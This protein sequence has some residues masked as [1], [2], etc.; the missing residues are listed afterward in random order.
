MNRVEHRRHDETKH[1]YDKQC[2]A[3]PGE[4]RIDLLR[5]VFKASRKLGRAKHEQ[6]IA[7]Y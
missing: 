7:K 6:K 4:I 5:L 2:R 1:R 3:H